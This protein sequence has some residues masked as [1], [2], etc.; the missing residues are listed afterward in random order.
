MP[1]GTQLAE[2]ARSALTDAKDDDSDECDNETGSGNGRSRSRSR[3]DNDNYGDDSDRYAGNA[4]HQTC[5][6]H[7]TCV[8]YTRVECVWGGGVIFVSD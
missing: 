7:V 2:L 1:Q 8:V 3:I 6:L 5:V 4:F